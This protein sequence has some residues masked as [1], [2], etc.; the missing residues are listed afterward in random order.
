M[1]YFKS[2][3]FILKRFNFS[4]ADRLITIL[5]RDYGKIRVLAKGVRKISS[6]RAPHLE[7]F[8]EVKLSFYQGR[9][10]FYLTEVDTL[11]SF[12]R[13]RNNLN[14]IALAYQ[15]CELVDRMCPEEQKQEDIYGLL[16]KALTYLDH[17]DIN[18]QKRHFLNINQRF[19][20]HLLYKLG[21]INNQDLF[22]PEEYAQ[23][24]MESRLSS[25]KFFLE[26]YNL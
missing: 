10:F 8:N 14:K 5:T 20:L 26:T 24:I 12:P 19:I 6:K 9:N 1:R 22:E 13:L 15:M 18:N 25:A 7:I 3:G 2:V 21:F 4:E 17:P 16:D 11:K 23:S